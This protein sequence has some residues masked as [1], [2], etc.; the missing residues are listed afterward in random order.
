MH[1]ATPPTLDALKNFIEGNP[2]NVT[3]GDLSSYLEVLGRIKPKEVQIYSIDRPVPNS[4]ICLVQKDRLAR[5]AAWG[6]KETGIK[7]RP[8]YLQKD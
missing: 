5:I 1:F 3:E 6:E 4:S 8:F 2:S 7:I